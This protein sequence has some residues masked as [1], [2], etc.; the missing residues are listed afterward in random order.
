MIT[1]TCRANRG[2]T[3]AFLEAAERLQRLYDNYARAEGNEDVTWHLVLT[4]DETK[5]EI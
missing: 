4:R 2:T 5:G 3:P 1:P